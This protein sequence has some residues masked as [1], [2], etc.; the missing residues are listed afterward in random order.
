MF[1]KMSYKSL[2][3]IGTMEQSFHFN[4]TPQKKFCSEA[5]CTNRVCMAGGENKSTMGDQC[6]QESEL[7]CPQLAKFCCPKGTVGRPKK[8]SNG[9]S[10]EYTSTVSLPQHSCYKEDSSRKD[11]CKMSTPMRPP[12]F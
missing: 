1:N 11:I 7:G 6:V 2:G 8:Y 12:V 4:V 10:F 3:A 5:R 9:Y